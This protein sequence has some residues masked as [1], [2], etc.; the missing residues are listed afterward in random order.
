MSLGHHIIDKALEDLQRLHF[1]QD[2]R[3]EARDA[4]QD[5]KDALLAENADTDLQRI[6][7][8]LA[9]CEAAL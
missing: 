4:L 3:L 7:K 9:I 8:A 2:T 5:V 1:A 6:A